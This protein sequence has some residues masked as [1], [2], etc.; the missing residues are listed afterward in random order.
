[1]FCF[2]E[3]VY[4]GTNNIFPG[5]HFRK[6]FRKY[7]NVLFIIQSY[8]EVKFYIVDTIIIVQFQHQS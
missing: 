7:T 4:I 3:N 1:M 2:A 8:D 5:S 6:Y